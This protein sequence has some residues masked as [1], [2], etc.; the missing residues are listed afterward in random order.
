MVDAPVHRGNDLPRGVDELITLYPQRWA[1]WLACFEAVEDSG[2]ELLAEDFGE[3]R[4]QLLSMQRLGFTFDAGFVA[5]VE[6]LALTGAGGSDD[7]DADHADEW[8]DF[9]DPRETFQQGEDG[10]AVIAKNPGFQTTPDAYAVQLDANRYALHRKD[11]DQLIGVLTR[12][13]VGL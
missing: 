6:A 12:V 4:R 5:A 9:D 2:D 3:F 7:E 11:D 10:E 1:E 13:G 8:I